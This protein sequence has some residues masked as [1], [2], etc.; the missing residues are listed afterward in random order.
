[1]NFINFI[2]LF[3]IQFPNFRCF[4]FSVIMPIYNTGRY[5]DDA[6]MSLINQ[7]IGFENI[8]LIIVNDG[9]ID[10]SEEMALK[11][12]N[13]YPNN[14]IYIK[15]ENGGVSKAKNIGM[16]YATGNYI[17]FLDPDD[18]WDSLAFSNILSFFQK[19]KNIEIVVT[20]IK[21]FELKE[22]YHPLDYKFYKTRIVNLG[23]EYNCIQ[24]TGASII[25]KSS[26]IKGKKFDEGVFFY[27]DV[28]FINYILLLKPIMGVIREA[29]YYYRI[30][31]D[32]TSNSQNQKK[33]INFYLYSL[34]NVHQYL[35]N[36]SQKIY[37]KTLPFIQ[38]YIG[39]EVLKQISSKNYLFL[40]KISYNRCCE[41]VESLVSQI[42]EKYVLEQKNPSYRIKIFTLSRKYHKDLRYNIIFENESL[43]YS[44]HTI[45]DFKKTKDLIAWKIL[46]IKDKILH[47][48]GIDNFWMPREKYFYFCKFGNKSFFPK[49]F[50]YTNND[51]ITMYGNIEKGRIVNFDIPLQNTNIQFFHFYISYNEKIIEIFPSLG[52]FTHIPPI[53]NGY[54]ISE[55]YIVKYINRSLTIFINNKNLVKIFE[56]QYIKQL[57]K[58]G[59]INIIKLRKESIK[60][61]NK[62]NKKEI[63]I[64][65][66]GRDK[67][68]DNGEFFFRYLKK[69]NLKGKIICF[70]IR[71]NCSDYKRLKKLGNILDSNSDNYL[72]IFL[73]ASKI[74]S[75]MS[76]SWV[77][78]PFGEDRKY[79]RDLFQFDSIFL[80]NGI[81][82]DDLSKYL[83]RLNK[84]YSLF[85]TS[86]KKEYESIFNFNYGY[87]KNNV[88]LTGLP[89]YDNLYRL[90]K[91]IKKEKKILIAPT[92]RIFI[93]GTT[94]KIT[95]E[96][97]HSDTFKFTDYFNFYN[98][99]I[100]DEKLIVFMK[101]FNYK[102][103][104]CLHPFFSSQDI[105]FTR[106][107]IFSIKNKCNYQKYLLISS[108]LVTDYSSIFFDFAYLRK[109]VIYTHF[110]YKD[111]RRYQYQNGFFDYE[112]DG[113]GTIAHDLKSTINKIIDEIE[114]NCSLKKIYLKKINKFFTY[115]DEHNNDRLFLKLLHK[116]KLNQQIKESISTILFLII[117]LI[118][119]KFISMKKI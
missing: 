68:G 30:R 48:E 40:D 24:T 90:N 34:N 115:F 60:Y 36:Y 42:D 37:N 78:N 100:N 96:S 83:N 103:I 75:S 31:A 118:C 20:R 59:K 44:N 12:Q 39:Y 14:I 6:I 56:K 23:Q 108:I 41:K 2:I 67:A 27:E 82:K 65:S 110:D 106:N 98:S 29:I 1:M 105:D 15:I 17:N 53:I 104:F 111:Y 114:N 61:R 117:L 94:N 8:Q 4:I 112:K 62:I 45:I 43:I 7:T 69:K 107:N 95:Y 22:Y 80:Q 18:K 63:W 74:I 79:I 77:D 81:L 85:V 76:H 57:K 21:F 89:R 38:F 46:D 49:Y 5:L 71:K 16:E 119:A 19:N 58:E 72:Y 52:K 113:F 50:Y 101:Q 93:K 99:L 91:I 86:T 84:N 66:D 97:I 54:Y 35:L 88:I 55:N 70:M 51:F 116:N 109:P 92:W 47:L 9:S 87:N 73:K 11:Y 33:E 3:I 25:F 10:Q 26:L 64:I 102:G 13:E 28:K 32:F